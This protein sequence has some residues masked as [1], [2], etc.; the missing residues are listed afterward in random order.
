[1]NSLQRQPRSLSR[2]RRRE[3]NNPTVSANT[4][5]G[6][7]AL[8]FAT[9]ALKA[10]ATLANNYVNILDG[11]H[12]KA[13]VPIGS[14]ADDLVS[15]QACD[16]VSGDSLVLNE[17]VVTLT[18]LQVSEQICRTTI[19]PT[20]HGAATSMT[21]TDY[22][23]QE[24]VNFTLGLTA[25]KAA[26][27]NENWIWKGSASFANGF[28]S[29]DGAFDAPGLAASSLA[30]ATPVAITAITNSIAIAQFNIVYTKAATDKPGILSKPDL[31]FYCSQKTYAL[32][33]QQLAG[34]GAHSASLAGQG[35]NNMGP[36]GN[37]SQLGFM[38]IPINVCPGMF[39]DAII[40]TY[41]SNLVFAS[42]L[43]TDLNTVQWIPTYLY[44]GSDNIR[45]VMRFA[46]G[47]VCPVPADVILGKTF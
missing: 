45:I 38:G 10:N 13:V 43:G 5:A 27:I 2:S 19:Y 42:N 28:L 30:S 32:Y 11:I 15:A 23:T 1:M 41:Q 37:F 36:I 26:E 21:T 9:P 14:A 25:A 29:N 7:L 47:T 8:P 35:M 6:N 39:D 4:Y 17:A 18:E 33:S 12:F 22:M 3:F 34:L 44:D 40:L 20:W 31:A 46:Y 24:Y 16:F